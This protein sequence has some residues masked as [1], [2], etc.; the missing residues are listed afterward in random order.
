[1]THKFVD[2]IS[3]K[4]AEHWMMAQKALLFSAKK[5]HSRK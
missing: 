1:M 2:N 4:T 3:F 5:K